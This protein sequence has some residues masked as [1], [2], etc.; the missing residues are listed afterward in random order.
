MK[1]YKRDGMMLDISGAVGDLC[2]KKHL[3]YAAMRD[4]GQEQKHGGQTWLACP[5]VAVRGFRER[6][7]GQPA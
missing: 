3:V 4:G 7:G 6:Q 2:Y 5:G 1:E